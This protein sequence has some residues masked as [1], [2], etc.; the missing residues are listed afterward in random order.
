MIQELEDL[1]V[2][3]LASYLAKYIEQHAFVNAKGL[4]RQFLID[5]NINSRNN[6]NY[7]K[8][9]RS[10][11][12]RFGKLISEAVDKNLLARYNGHCYKIV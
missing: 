8:Y 10:L 3:D 11:S 4:S 9:R 6:R 1:K 7:S 2:K 5:S 12:N